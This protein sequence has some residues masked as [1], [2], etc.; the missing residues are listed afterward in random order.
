MF[1]MVSAPAAGA[2]GPETEAGVAAVLG[3]GAS[4]DE[5]VRTVRRV[6]HGE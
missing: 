4:A 3:P 2:V 1:A 5:V 6:V